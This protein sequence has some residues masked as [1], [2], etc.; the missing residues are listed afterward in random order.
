MLEIH[1]VLPS[2]PIIKPKKIE[3][4]DHHPEKQQHR[5]KQELREQRAEPIQHIDEIA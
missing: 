2:L 3:R 5:K 1:P 4:D